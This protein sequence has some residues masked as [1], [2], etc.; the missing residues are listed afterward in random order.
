MSFMHRISL[1]QKFMIL[2]LLALVMVAAPTLVL[3]RNSAAEI[4]VVERED[5]ECTRLPLSSELFR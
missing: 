4:A 2:G 1:S 5:M 3:Y